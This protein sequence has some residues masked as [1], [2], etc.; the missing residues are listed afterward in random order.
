MINCRQQ[1]LLAEVGFSEAAE[2][3]VQRPYSFSDF[4]RFLRSE[5]KGSVRYGT[6]KST[7]NRVSDVSVTVIVT[8]L[9]MAN[10]GLVKTA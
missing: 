3:T 1:A 5:S 4:A 9:V 8:C 10:S 2:G 6:V 7:T